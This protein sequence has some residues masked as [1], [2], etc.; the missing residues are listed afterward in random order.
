MYVDGIRRKVVGT[1][2]PKMGTTALEKNSVNYF[3][4]QLYSLVSDVGC[5][6][7]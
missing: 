1:N 2:K 7:R 3:K 6:F 5:V 4:E